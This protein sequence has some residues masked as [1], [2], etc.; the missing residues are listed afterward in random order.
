[1]AGQTQTDP[2]AGWAKAALEQYELK[3]PTIA[4]LGHSDNITYRVEELDGTRYL[5]RLH[6][7]ALHYWAGIRQLPDVIGSELTWLEALAMEGGFAVQRPVRTRKGEM[8]AVVE[9]EN[10]PAPLPATLLTWLEGEHFSASSENASA[11]IRRLGSLVAR[12]HRFASTWSPPAGFIRPQYDLDHFKRIYAR[13][14][15]G[16]DLGVFS[17]EIYWSLRAASQVILNQIE[18]LPV[19]PQCWGMVH[20]DLHVGNFLVGSGALSIIPIDFSFCGFGHYLFDVSVCLAG[21]LKPSLAPAFLSGYRG[22]LPLPEEDLRAVEAY[23]LTGRLSYY[24]YQI[25]NPSEKAWL[26]R[27]IPEVAQNQVKRFLG[28]QRILWDL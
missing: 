22:V 13:L 19:N 7:P 25:D 3:A 6:R 21:G 23:A 26:Q 20:A 14:L 1:M 9:V 15:R 18:A 24:A 5:L 17:E 27:R 10:E 16:V 11:Q 4:F 2:F 28:G 12:M 8:V